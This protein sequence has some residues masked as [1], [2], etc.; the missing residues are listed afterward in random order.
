MG[1]AGLNCT[2]TYHDGKVTRGYRVR[3]GNLTG[4]VQMIAAE[5]QARTARAYYPHKTAGQQFS[6]QV[7]L[8]NWDERLDFT[9]WLASYAQWALDPNIIR[10]SFPL[11]AVS[12]PSR[13]FV[14]HG[15]PLAGYEWGAHTGM[16][17]FTPVVMF[18]PGLSPGQGAAPVA[19][20]S[21]VNRWAAFSS[22][23]AIQYF[24]PF[25]TQLAASQVPQD[26][27]NVVPPSPPVVP[28]TT[29]VP[30]QPI[31][32]GTP[33]TTTVPPP[34]QPVTV[35]GPVVTTVPPGAQG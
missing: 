15:I 28:P 1:R 16:M 3:A 12:V 22:D 29:T 25:G 13:D 7:L 14:Q 31:P 26:Y 17:M 35:G 24:Y 30:G 33:V 23:P 9:N 6:V 5:D 21:V 27:G 8:K 19:V 20:S 18:E 32:V 2:L 4:G 11:M 34:G 10:S